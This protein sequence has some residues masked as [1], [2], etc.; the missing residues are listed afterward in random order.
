MTAALL[1]T[2]ALAGLLALLWERD[3]RRHQWAEAGRAQAID[4]AKAARSE[5]D[6][7]LATAASCRLA[8][9]E[10]LAELVT[11]R[12]D[13]DVARQDAQVRARTNGEAI[14]STGRGRIEAQARVKEIIR[15][16]TEAAEFLS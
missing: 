10:T 13:L 3:R 1:A 4:D 14:A 11:A 6:T 5:R 15:Q 2:L 9:S 8:A 7:A 16:A 12:Q